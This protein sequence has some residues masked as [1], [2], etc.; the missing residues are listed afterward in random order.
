MGLDEASTVETSLGC[1]DFK[2]VRVLMRA[3]PFWAGVGLRGTAA[4]VLRVLSAAWLAPFV[5]RGWETG[6]KGAVLLPRRKDMGPPRDDFVPSRDELV[7]SRDD[8]VPSRDDLVP[9]RD[10][11][12]P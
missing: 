8:L 10:D 4:W 5:V 2:C 3:G 11:L 6:V 12:V 9:P 1:G 7:P